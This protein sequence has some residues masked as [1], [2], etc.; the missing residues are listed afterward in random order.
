V[1]HDVLSVLLSR[2]YF[3]K[4]ISR[5]IQTNLDMI[6]DFVNSMQSKVH[7]KVHQKFRGW[8]CLQELD[9]STTVSFPA[10][11]IIRKI[12]FAEDANKKYRRRLYPSRF[13]LGRL[14][15]QL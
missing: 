7:S 14:C 9:M 3:R 4:H 8:I 11:D 5:C 15:K 13:K 12:E 1:V 2:K 6:P 10:F